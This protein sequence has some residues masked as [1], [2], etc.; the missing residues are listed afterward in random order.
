MATAAEME[1][2]REAEREAVELVAG[3]VAGT[4]EEREEA[5]TEE[6]R[7]EAETEEEREEVE[8]EEE[9]EEAETVAALVV[10]TVAGYCCN[11]HRVSVL[12][13]PIQQVQKCLFLQEHNTRLEHLSFFSPLYTPVQTSAQLEFSAS[14]SQFFPHLPQFAT[15]CAFQGFM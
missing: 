4:E 8:T 2:E 13:L 12:L 7:E 9:R 5:E 11:V 1:A 14:T 15:H 3:T 10:G 6:E